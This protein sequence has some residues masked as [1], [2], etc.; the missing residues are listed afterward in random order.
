MATM[1]KTKGLVRI[2]RAVGYSLAGF[3]AAWVNEEA[4][5]QEVILVCALMPIGLWVG[6]TGVERALLIGC[7]FLILLTELL[8]SAIEAIADGLSEEWHP[9]VQRAKDLG[10]AAV[11]VSLCGTCGV[12]LLILL[13]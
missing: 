13:D 11:F 6:R 3:K 4:F 10:S 7:L 9:L 12:W 5:R 8:N 1:K 2:V